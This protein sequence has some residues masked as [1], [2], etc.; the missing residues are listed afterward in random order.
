MMSTFVES[1]LTM[2]LQTPLTLDQLPPIDFVIISHNHY[3]HLDSL[4]VETL[5]DDVVWIVPKGFFILEAILYFFF[6]FFF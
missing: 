2:F 6:F 5:G 3:D 1:N 4:V